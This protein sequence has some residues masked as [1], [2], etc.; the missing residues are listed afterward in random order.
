MGPQRSARAPGP[1]QA[2]AEGASSGLGRSGK[3]GPPAT[4]GL[5]GWG[6][7]ERSPSLRRIR[8]R[9]KAGALAETPP[10][11]GRRALLGAGRLGPAPRAPGLSQE[12][13]RQ[14]GA[15][16]APAALRERAAGAGRGTGARKEGLGRGVDAGVPRGGPAPPYPFRPRV[17]KANGR[18]GPCDSG[19][20][21][22]TAAHERDTAFL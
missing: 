19:R 3:N 11:R 7:A 6:R 1:K 21:D 10:G 9:S 8:A 14:A 13:P 12:P 4:G 18:L 16:A 5:W 20:G 15:W 2:R 17:S 22:W